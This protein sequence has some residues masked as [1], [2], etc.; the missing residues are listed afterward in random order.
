MGQLLELFRNSF[1]ILNDELGNAQLTTGCL[2]SCNHLNFQPDQQHSRNLTRTRVGEQI[3]KKTV[4]L[5]GHFKYCHY[6][7]AIDTKLRKSGIQKDSKNEHQK[8]EKRKE[9]GGEKRRK[10][11]EY[12]CQIWNQAQERNFS[13]TFVTGDAKSS[14]GLHHGVYNHTGLPLLVWQP[15]ECRFL[16]VLPSDP[17]SPNLREER[18]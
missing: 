11:M 7:M 5:S 12:S 2:T 4:N 15:Q 8:L 6:Y 13:A 14:R 16:S 18:E 3:R 10:N 1:W 9:G 17:P